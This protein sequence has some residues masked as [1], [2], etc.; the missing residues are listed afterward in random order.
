MDSDSD[1]GNRVAPDNR[2]T[3]LDYVDIASGPTIVVVL[4]I[5]LLSFVL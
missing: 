3:F 2:L 4:L 5:G 1:T